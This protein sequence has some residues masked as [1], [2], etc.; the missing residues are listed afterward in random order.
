MVR[1]GLGTIEHA[2]NG[3]FVVREVWEETS[4]ST[5]KGRAGTI[6]VWNKIRSPKQLGKLPDWAVEDRT[7]LFAKLPEQG[8][9]NGD[10]LCA[11]LSH[12]NCRSY[13]GFNHLGGKWS[14]QKADKKF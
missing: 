4:S 2:S 6:W 3:T 14:L 10:I 8:L 7:N 12:A 5:W 11:L 1:E 9:K 13:R